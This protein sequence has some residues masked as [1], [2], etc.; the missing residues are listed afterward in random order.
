MTTHL[1]FALQLL[2]YFPDLRLTADLSHYSVGHEFAWPVD[3]VDH[4]LIHRILNNAWG[5]HGRIASRE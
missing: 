1:L 5:L 2:D 4:A 3:A